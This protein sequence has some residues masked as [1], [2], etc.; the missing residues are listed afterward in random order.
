MRVTFLNPPENNIN[1]RSERGGERGGE[2]DEEKG[3]EGEMSV[4]RV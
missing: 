3:E 4:L 2:R 1:S